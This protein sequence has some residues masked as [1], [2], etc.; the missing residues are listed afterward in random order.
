[1]NDG[2]TEYL[3]FMLAGLMALNT[4]IFIV[5]A[6]AY[7]YKEPE[8]KAY[9]EIEKTVDP[10][11]PPLYDAVM[12]HHHENPG[13]FGDPESTKLWGSLTDLSVNNYISTINRPNLK[14]YV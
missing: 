13:Y 14:F 12:G 5:V 11:K 10:G 6:R 1:M 4:L 3:F 9:I 7:K 8:E 2:K